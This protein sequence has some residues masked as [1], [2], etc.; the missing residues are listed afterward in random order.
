MVISI[1]VG[2]RNRD[3]QLNYFLKSLTL[4]KKPPSFEVIIVNYGGSHST[5]KLIHTYTSLNIR[6][7]FVDDY[8][9]YNESRAKNIGIRKASGEIVICTNADLIYSPTVLSDFYK[10]YTDTEGKYLYQLQR[11]ALKKNEN[12]SRIFHSDFQKIAKSKGRLINRRA[13]GDFQAAKRNIWF[14]VRGYDEHFEG[15][16]EMDLD[17][18]QRMKNNGIN[19]FWMK[20]NSIIFHQ[21]HPYSSKINFF[22]NRQLAQK[23]NDI[24]PNGKDWGEINKK[25]LLHIIINKPL[26]TDIKNLKSFDRLLLF[27]HINEKQISRN[28]FYQEMIDTVH[29]PYPD[30]VLFIDTISSEHLS[31]IISEINKIATKDFMFANPIKLPYVLRPLK[32]NVSN[33]YFYYFYN[34]LFLRGRIFRLMSKNKIQTNLLFFKEIMECG[35]IWNDENL[36]FRN[37]MNYSQNIEIT[38]KEILYDFYSKI[39][40]KLGVR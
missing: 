38:W 35:Y 34:I 10:T 27:F 31:T 36:L 29:N 13:C 30:Y 23:A 20:N 26:D 37:D 8:G 7:Y 32:K 4:Q 22:I 9:V 16:G 3:S 17:L 14:S 40:H 28:K 12:I 15:W 5:Q 21:Y 39:K 25:Y 6:Y 19:Q 1:V 18:V 33:A 24:V 2:T 11:H